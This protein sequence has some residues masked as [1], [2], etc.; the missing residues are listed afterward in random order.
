MASV[1]EALGMSLP[2]RGKLRVIATKFEDITST[3][4]NTDLS[5]FSHF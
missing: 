1:V 3:T 5:L 2:G 4:E